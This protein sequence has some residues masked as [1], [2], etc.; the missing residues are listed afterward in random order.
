MTEV[1]SMNTRSAT[2]SPTVDYGN[3]FHVEF[4]NNLFLSVFVSENQMIKNYCCVSKLVIM[5][6]A[7]KSL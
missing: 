2:G 1:H 7:Q 4:D 5:E 6:K 3:I